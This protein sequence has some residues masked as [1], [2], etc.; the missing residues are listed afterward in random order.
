MERCILQ[1][2]PLAYPQLQLKHLSGPTILP[3]AG[4]HAG[5]VPGQSRLGSN[6]YSGVASHSP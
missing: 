2:A 5:A 1:E 3:I 4:T 6:E